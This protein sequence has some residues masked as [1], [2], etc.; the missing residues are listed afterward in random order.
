MAKL[1]TKKPNP[2]NPRKPFTDSQLDAFRKSLAE[3][4]DLS[5]IVFN[6]KTKQLVGGHKRC[7]QFRQEDPEVN[8][9]E[10]LKAPDSTGTVAWGHVEIGGT[11]FTYREVEWTKTKEAAGNIAANQHG[12]EFDLGIVGQIVSEFPNSFDLDVL[13]FERPEIESFLNTPPMTE[14]QE[15]PKQTLKDRFLV[16]PFSVLDCRQGYW[17]DRKRLWLALGIKSEIGRGVNVLDMSA[18]MVGIPPGPDREK[19]NKNRRKKA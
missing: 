10:V 1:S 11:R 15:V 5:G 16:P 9:T 14:A 7:E 2:R 6:R 4:G 8:I 13:G 18:T 3:F 12:A 17:Q 19:W